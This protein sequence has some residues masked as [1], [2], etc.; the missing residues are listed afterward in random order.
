MTDVINIYEMDIV[1]YIWQILRS[2]FSHSI[3]VVV[4][5]FYL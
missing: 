3:F 2:G 1:K 4:V 5:D